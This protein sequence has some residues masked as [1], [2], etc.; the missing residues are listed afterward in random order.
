MV[1]RSFARN[2]LALVAASLFFAVAARADDWRIVQSTGPLWVH[3]EGMQSVSLGPDAVLPDGATLTTGEGSRILL[4]H[5]TQ[6]LI[7]GPNAVVTIPAGDSG[8]I[9][10]VLQRAGAVEFD[11]DR[12]NSPHFA[13]ETPFL[14]AIVKGTHFTVKIDEFGANVA[15]VRGLVE[16]T[17]LASGEKVDVPPGQNANVTGGP[18]GKLTVGGGGQRAAVLQGAPRAPLVSVVSA[19]ELA[20]LRSDPSD[21][22]GGASPVA[23]QPNG[24]LTALG[25]AGYGGGDGNGGNGGGGSLTEIG[26]VG[27]APVA[28]GTDQAGPSANDV[29]AAGGGGGTM[30]T[31]GVEGD[32]S[33]LRA[34][35]LTRRDEGPI[36]TMTIAISVGLSIL[37]AV[38]FAYLRGRAG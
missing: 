22:E 35:T 20:S 1:F 30:A 3:T 21:S 19:G 26:S 17:D 38:G 16:V 6:T 4:A 7:V 5:G 12:Q 9:T 2:G 25:A 15:V 29:A 33:R 10:T 11:V 28:S 27:T 37:L 36:S 34:L 24:A 18:D 14:A 31:Y 8:G 32:G 13:V 23:S